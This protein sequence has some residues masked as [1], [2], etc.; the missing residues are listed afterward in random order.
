MQRNLLPMTLAA[1]AIAFLLAA[2]QFTAVQA[3]EHKDEKNAKK[4]ADHSAAKDGKVVVGTFDQRTALR[5]YEQ[6]FMAKRRKIMREAQ[7]EVQKQNGGGG[8]RRQQMMQAQRKAQPRVQKA[9]QELQKRMES[10][11]DKVLPKVAKENNVDLIVPQVTYKS[12]KIETKDISAEV[13]KAIGK[14]APETEQP[15]RQGLQSILQGQGQG[16]A[17]GQQGK[18]AKKQGSGQ[19]QGQGQ[20]TKQKKGGE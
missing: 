8:N 1:T 4:D 12:D 13:T 2:G 16:K 15:K 3:D 11:M 9:G 19:K 20:S 17:Q 6:H 7:K 14:V 10:D 5:P 18:D